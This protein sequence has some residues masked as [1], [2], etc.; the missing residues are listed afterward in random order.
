M[1]HL[2]LRAYNRSFVSLLLAIGCLHAGFTQDDIRSVEQTAGQELR[3]SVDNGLLTA[4]IRNHSL[5][6]VLE[7][8]SVIAHFTIVVA[9]GAADRPVSLEV[10]QIRLDDGLRQL[11]SDHDSFF[12]YGGLADSP[13]SLRTVW[14]YRKGTASSLQ[15]VPPEVWASSKDLEAR[16]SN[17]DP[18][19]RALA[20]E[21]LLSRPDQSS[22][23]AVIEALRGTTEKDHLVRQRIFSAAI[24]KGTALPP[25]V[26]ADLAR[27][28]PSEQIRWL[29][30]DALSEHSSVKQTAEAALT[31]PSEAVR[32]RAK[33]I[34]ADL[35]AVDYRLKNPQ[36]GGEVSP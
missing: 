5:R 8:L 34:L 27:L 21:G 22:R 20:Y 11:L 36:P 2:M 9:D 24:T 6:R 7:E 19:N 16:L 26:L 15:P 4:T 35:S 31:D 28:D 13:S 17:P 33:Q 23:D 30:L 10:K 25:D 14:V 12:F 18:E 29:A 1:R 3:V 32:E